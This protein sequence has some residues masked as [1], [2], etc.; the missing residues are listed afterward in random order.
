MFQPLQSLLS[1]VTYSA[2][3]SVWRQPPAMHEQ[4]GMNESQQI[5]I[6]DTEILFWCFQPLN[7]VKVILS[8]WMHKNRQHAD[9]VSDFWP[10]SPGQA[11]FLPV[12][13]AAPS[14]F[15]APLHTAG[16]AIWVLGSRLCLLCAAAGTVHWAQGKEIFAQTPRTKIILSTLSFCICFAFGLWIS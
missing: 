11:Q 14:L 4:V 7:C 6:T 12:L 1:I 3:L 13:I 5:F 2:Q 15:L 8:S 10:H 9:L 16:A